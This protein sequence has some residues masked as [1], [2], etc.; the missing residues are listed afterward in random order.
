MSEALT[1]GKEGVKLSYGRML[2]DSAGGY[3]MLLIAAHLVVYNQIPIPDALKS[4]SSEAK[5]AAIVLAGVFILL[6]GPPFGLALNSASWFLLGWIQVLFLNG[7]AKSR[8]LN[9]LVYVLA[10]HTGQEYNVDLLQETFT[11]LDPAERK[12]SPQRHTVYSQ[13]HVIKKLIS[14]RFP[15][16]L[17]RVEYLTGIKIFIRNLSLLC[18]ATA[19][20]PWLPND[21]IRVN[22]PANM[23]GTLLIAA[24]GLTLLACL[25]ELYDALELMFTAHCLCLSCAPAVYELLASEATP[26]ARQSRKPETQPRS[27]ADAV[28]RSGPGA[29]PNAEPEPTPMMERMNF[30]QCIR[31]LLDHSPK[32][33]SPQPTP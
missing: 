1:F 4:G 25:L 15:H 29:R 21:V 6:L 2:S 30:A 33:D 9:R 3:V 16:L 31:A 14:T 20:L 18:L 28:R 32:Q 13:L 7:W 19:L 8:K 5:S 27:T 23:V 11:F 22:L 26:V 10:Y 17:G 24:L 12:K